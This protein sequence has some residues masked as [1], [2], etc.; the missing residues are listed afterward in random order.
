VLILTLG[1]DA[2]TDETVKRSGYKK[3]VRESSGYY[4]R[5]IG[6]REGDAGSRSRAA[7]ESPEGEDKVIDDR[8]RMQLWESEAESDGDG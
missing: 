1:F 4:F 6:V 3:P 5:C 7:A 8:G 2:R